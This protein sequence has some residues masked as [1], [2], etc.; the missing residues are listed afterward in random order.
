ML[1]CSRFKQHVSHYYA[2]YFELYVSCHTSFVLNCLSVFFNSIQAKYFWDTYRKYTTLY[3][4]GL[5]IIPT[6]GNCK[7]ST[8]GNWLTPFT[9]LFRYTFNYVC[10]IDTSDQF[11]SQGAATCTIRR[12]RGS[13]FLEHRSALQ[14]I[15]ISSQVQFL[16]SACRF[17]LLSRNI[18]QGS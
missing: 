16:F 1:Y 18:G 5:Q 8:K 13:E 11:I 3:I 17:V 14:V 9:E 10:C 4:H 7:R 15:Y 2:L 6:E 12:V